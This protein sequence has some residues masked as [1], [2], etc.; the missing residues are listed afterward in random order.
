MSSCGIAAGAR[1]VF[2]TL[3]KDV[4]ARSLPCAV[5]ATGCIGACHAEPL[6][7]VRQAGGRTFLYG[8]VDETKVQS[9][10]AGHLQG[11][12]PVAEL[13]IP[14]DYPYLAKQKRIVL[15][16]CG[17]IDPES[18]DQYLAHDGYAALKK[19]L[20]AMTPYA[21][22]EEVKASGLRG[23]GGAIQHLADLLGQGGEREGLGDEAHP[24]LQHPPM[25][26]DVRRVAGHVQALQPRARGDAAARQAAARSSAA[27]PR[28]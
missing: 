20:A 26:D 8:N 17:V 21:V 18:I 13:L 25:R 16:H 3:T 22:I 15:A 10:I 23:R 7:E 5:V 1:V 6:V 2:E 4:A 19:V 14:A 11:G 24:L 28:R 27:S 12:T 9:I